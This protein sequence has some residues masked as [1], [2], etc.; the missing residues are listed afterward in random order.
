MNRFD[1]LIAARRPLWLDYADYAGALLA[2]GQAPWLDVSA[3]V[4]WQRKA[5][6]LL[7]SDVVELPLGAV[8]AAWLDAHATLRDAMAAKR[9]VGY[10]LRTLL[11]DDDLR[12]HL[13]ELAGGLRA[14]FASQPLAI[15]CPSPRRWLLESYRA[16]HGEVPEFDDDDVDSAAV[17]LADFLRLFGEI[18]IDVLLL[19]ESLDSAPSDAASLACCQPVLNVAAH[20]R[21]IVGMATPAGRCEGDASLDFVVAPEAVERRYVAQQI[22]AAFWTGAAVPDCPAGGFRYA[23]IPRDAQP[24]AVLQR[25]ASLR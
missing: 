16:A 12:H 10:P 15:A 5:Q 23:G 8:A 20:Y 24:E 9:R 22:P 11:A 13:A 17:Y 18:G 4:A 19:Q 3:L 25:L 14:S 21:W 2:G 1:E 7:R 6:G